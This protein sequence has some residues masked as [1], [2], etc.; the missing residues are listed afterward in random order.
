MGI[1]P[2]TFEIFGFPIS[3]TVVNTWGVMAVLLIL[4]ALAGRAVARMPADKPPKGWVNVAEL[5]VESMYT[6]TRS[7]MGQGRGG[8]APYVG[9][10]GLF[11]AVSNILGVIGIRPPTADLN[12]TVAMASIT[13]FNIT[14]YSLKTR[15]VLGYARR[16]LE[17]L[18]FMLPLNIISEIAL[19]VSMALRL[20]GSMTGGAMIMGLIYSFAPLLVPVLPHLYF[21]LFSGIIQSF[22]FVMLTVTFVASGMED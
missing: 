17:P 15:G 22:I 18:P 7:S 9:T 14:Y 20:F 5:V 12:T 3:E 1:N 16:F 4:G 11:L 8:F 2:R 13:F 21:D 19:P 6:F 10:L